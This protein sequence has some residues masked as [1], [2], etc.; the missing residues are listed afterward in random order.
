MSEQET[1]GVSR[2]LIVDDVE[3]NRFTLRDIIT[4]MGYTPVLTENGL[5]ALKVARRMH[6]QLIIT[7]IAMPEMDGYELCQTLK[8][9][10]DTRD[11]PVIFISAFDDPQDV[12]QGFNIGGE[13]YITKPLIPAVVKARVGLHL[14][15]CE[16]NLS[17]QETNRRL[18]SS[19]NQQLHQIEIEKKNVLYALVRVARENSGYDVEQMER[20]CYNCKLLAEA[21]QLSVKYGHLISDVYIETIAMAAPLCDLGNVALP[22]NILRKEQPLTDSE[23]KVLR[24]HTSIGAKI[25]KDIRDM[26][27]YNDF[28]QMSIDIANYHHEN[29]DGSGYPCGKKQEEIPLAAQIMAIVG[30]F[31]AL[32][33]KRAYRGSYST[34]E[35]LAIMEADAGKKYNPDILDILKKIVRQL[36]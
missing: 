33:E 29:W 30:A 24:T 20:I 1:R 27:D 3:A 13:D 32:T 4:D 36:H 23:R 19:V 15:L 12:V 5:Q 2:I 8:E 18:Q 31:C 28:L 26:G 35:A 6:P 11:I 22:T 17:L 21:M 9:D 25:L 7:D 16:A 34:E 14:K 10:A